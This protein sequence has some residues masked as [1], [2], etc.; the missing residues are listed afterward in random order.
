MRLAYTLDGTSEP[1]IYT[2]GSKYR[3]IIAVYVDLVTF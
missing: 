2:L 1:V 3:L